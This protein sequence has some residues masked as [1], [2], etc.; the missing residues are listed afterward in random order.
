MKTLT[1][2]TSILVVLLL[3]AGGGAMAS[4]RQAGGTI[5]GVVKYV[6]VPPSPKQIVI[7]KDQE[8]CGRKPHFDQSLIV[9]KDGA[10]A[11]AVVF[12]RD[13]KAAPKP[14]TLDFVQKGCQYH[15]HVLA[16]PAGSTIKIIN[17]D[18]ILHNIRTHSVRNPPINIAQPGFEKVVS[19]RIRQ[20]E[21]IRST[22]TSTTGCEPGGIRWP[23][24]IS[25]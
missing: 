8:V 25:P 7:T 10:I 11:N 9:G 3:A 5:T 13:I 4:T 20:P 15:P 1:L 12:I 18:G 17:D 6:G 21:L 19:V 24:P 2:T 16:F 22:V 23:T 14:E